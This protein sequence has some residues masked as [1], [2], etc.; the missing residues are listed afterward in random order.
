VFKK[1]QTVTG[2]KMRVNN[3]PKLQS[4]TRLFQSNEIIIPKS[5]YFYYAGSLSF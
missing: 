2:D 3:R 1:I 5:K 4:V